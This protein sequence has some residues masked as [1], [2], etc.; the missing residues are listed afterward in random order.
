MNAYDIT[1]LAT[2]ET[3]MSSEKNMM[4]NLV[5][6]DGKVRYRPIYLLVKTRN[7]EWGYL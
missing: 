6:S 5:T 2:T 4:Q 7:K 3:K 1:A